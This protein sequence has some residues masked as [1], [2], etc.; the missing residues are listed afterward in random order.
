MKKSLLALLLL[1]SILLFSGCGT[2]KGKSRPTDYDGD[3]SVAALID[4]AQ[5][6][7]EAGNT[8][9]AA[10]IYAMIEKSAGAADIELSDDQELVDEYQKAKSL[11][12]EFGR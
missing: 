8:E 11:A 7:E 10:R 3:N 2:K 6:L 12:S 1:F 9:A 5:R 4:Y